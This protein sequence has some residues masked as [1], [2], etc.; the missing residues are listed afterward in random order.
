MV[1]IICLYRQRYGHGR[2]KGTKRKT[3]VSMVWGGGEGDGQDCETCCLRPK[4][5][6]E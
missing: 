1:G 5:R 6:Q 3:M 2:R 4:T